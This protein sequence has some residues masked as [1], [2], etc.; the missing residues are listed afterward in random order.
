MNNGN[1][2]P[3]GCAIFKDPN[4]TLRFVNKKTGWDLYI[5]AGPDAERIIAEGMLENLSYFTE[6]TGEKIRAGT[7][8]GEKIHPQNVVNQ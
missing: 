8:R 6:I 2:L 5:A 1:I 7:I 3:D 4:V